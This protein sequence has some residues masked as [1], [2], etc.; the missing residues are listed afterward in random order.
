[1]EGLVAFCLG[2]ECWGWLLED[3]RL[4][5]LD[6]TVLVVEEMGEERKK[7]ERAVEPELTLSSDLCLR[8]LLARPACG[9]VGL[10]G[11]YEMLE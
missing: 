9:L 10:E 1:M 8:V 11:G 5:S 4:R 2:V 7:E 3:E 6:L